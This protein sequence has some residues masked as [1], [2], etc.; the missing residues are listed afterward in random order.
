MSHRKFALWQWHA[1][2]SF[3]CVMVHG[4][5]FSY[6]VRHPWPFVLTFCSPHQAKFYINL[7]FVGK[8]QLS[9]PSGTLN[10]VFRG[11][12]RHA[13]ASCLIFKRL[14]P[15]HRP[16]V[17]TQ[18]LTTHYCHTSYYRPDKSCHIQR[19][20]FEGPCVERASAPAAP[21]TST[22]PEPK[23]AYNAASRLRL[24]IHQTARTLNMGHR[25][26]EDMLQR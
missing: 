24:H 26:S 15:I 7:K 4:P 9:L 5:S 12:A 25:A 6:L 16:M 3:S 19:C 14:P 17:L 20:F 10:Q 23:V 18:L 22:Q 8:G 1:P 21:S 2:S 11:C 13:A